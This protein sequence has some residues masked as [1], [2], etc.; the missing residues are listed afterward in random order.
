MGQRLVGEFFILKISTCKMEYP[1][2][3]LWKNSYI[4]MHIPFSIY[5]ASTPLRFFVFFSNVFGMEIPRAVVFR[6]NHSK[7][8][9]RF[10]HRTNIAKNRQLCCRTLPEYLTTR[11]LTFYTLG[12]HE[13]PTYYRLEKFGV[14]RRETSPGLQ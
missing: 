1:E 3:R 6:S 4:I 2:V 14:K 12:L 5:V 7:K 8:V 11:Y 10:A 9:W 13:A